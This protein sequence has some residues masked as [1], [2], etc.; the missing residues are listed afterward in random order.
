MGMHRSGRGGRLVSEPQPGEHSVS[1][2][3]RLLPSVPSPCARS[4]SYGTICT[5]KLL[6]RGQDIERDQDL[7]YR[8]HLHA[9]RNED[10]PSAA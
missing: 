9:K 7:T 8:Q 6:R 3:K 10:E 5:Q 1:L 2:G 4:I